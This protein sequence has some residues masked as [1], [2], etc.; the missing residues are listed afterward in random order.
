MKQIITVNEDKCVGCNSCVRVCPVHAN[1]T[2]LK[3]GS[4]DEIVTTVDPKACINCGEC[5]KACSHG[6]RDYIDDIDILIDKLEKKDPIVLI[7]SSAI[8]TSFPKGKWRALLYWLRDIG[9][10]K[11]YDVGYGADINAYMQHQYFERNPEAKLLTQQCP[12][13]VNYVQMY[14]PELIKNLSPILSPEGCMAAYLRKYEKVREP[15]FLLSPCIAK[16]S[17][18]AREQLFDYNVTFR[19]LEEFARSRKVN[20]NTPADFSFDG[21][22]EGTIGR[23]YP[24][25]G[26]MKNT[27]M[28]FN[29]ELLIHT[30]EGP[31]TLYDRLERYAVTEE[32][33]KPDVLDVLNCENGCNHGSATPSIVASLTEVE[34][35]MDSIAVQSVKDTQ[36]KLLGFGKNKRFKDF[37]K[38]LKYED[39]VTRYH[40]EELNRPAP[41]VA[42]YNRIF[43]TMYKTDATSQNINCTACGDKSCHDMACAI[44]R[45]QNVR[46]NCVNYLKHSLKDSYSQLKDVYDTCVEQISMINEISVEMQATQ[47]QMKTSTDDISVKAEEL[48]NNISRLQKF[49]QSCLEYYKDKK[50]ENLT[51]AD[52]AKMQQFIAAIGTMTQSY[53]EVAKEFAD[54]SANIHEQIMT[55]SE[56]VEALSQ[57]S[58]NLQEVVNSENASKSE[59]APEPQ[60][61]MRDSIMFADLSKNRPSMVI[62]DD[63]GA[64]KNTT[65]L[66]V[67]DTDTENPPPAMVLHKDDDAKNPPPVMVLHKDDDEDKQTPPP[68]PVMVLHKDDDEDEQT[69]PPVPVMNHDDDTPDLPDDMLLVEG[70]TRDPEEGTTSFEDALGSTGEFEGVGD[71]I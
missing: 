63:N 24:M 68:V 35:M 50:L 23:L 30:A 62:H 53:Y 60:S 58:E 16:S 26:G 54:R 36:G 39:F 65:P 31:Q 52:F 38:T 11:I 44:F 12:A 67:L 5:V 45:G 6:A 66:R 59:P 17:E 47:A 14:R 22:L 9:N 57:M 55:A 69:P 3:E 40:S 56:A 10:A 13:V 33:K 48:S 71:M 41:T 61:T 32:G 2:R 37:D 8:R 29:Q 34:S 46:E 25:P 49:S 21:D 1:I 43:Q 27:L 28:M 7:V 18:A 51:E 64:E 15:M 42:D 19:R 70:A 4:K 20:L